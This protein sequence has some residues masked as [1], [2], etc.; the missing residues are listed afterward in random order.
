MLAKGKYTRAKRQKEAAMRKLPAEKRAAVLSALVEGNSINSTCR[1]TGVAKKTVLRLLADAGQFCADYHDVFV[2]CLG[3]KRIQMDEM[4]GFC[5]CKDK[6]KNAGAEGY[7]S[8]WTWIAMDADNKLVI[9]YRVGDRSADSANAFVRDVRERVEGRPQVTS[10]AY[11]PYDEAMDR[12]F[13]GDVDYAMLVKV[14]GKV[15]TEEQRRYSPPECKGCRKETKAG[16]P[17]FEHVST[18]FIERQNLTVRM[19]VRRMTRLTNAFSKKIENHE[20]AMA[21]HY[22]HYNFIRLH[23]KFRTT[24]AVMAGV[25]ERPLTMADLV[26]M[27]E[28]EEATLKGRLTDYIP[29]ASKRGG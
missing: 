17:D 21:I 10:D 6:A 3:T 4:W 19:S 2:R 9:S 7:G 18:S 1:M 22:F 25:A 26:R 15:G 5:G 23:S 16:N 29:S 12:A 13:K 14:F 11:G 24:P 20:H 27:I 28:A 8:V